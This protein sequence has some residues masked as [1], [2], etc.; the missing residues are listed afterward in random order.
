[1]TNAMTHTAETTNSA[2]PGHPVGENLKAMFLTKS[3]SVHQ[4]FHGKGSVAPRMSTLPDY[5]VV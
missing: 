1:M 2:K 4:V 5:F 3:I